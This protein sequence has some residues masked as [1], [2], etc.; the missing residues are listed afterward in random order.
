[1]SDSLNERMKEKGSMREN[2][3]ECGGEKTM[4]KDRKGEVRE[5]KIGK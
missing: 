1:M 5:E 3:E 2:K 4:S